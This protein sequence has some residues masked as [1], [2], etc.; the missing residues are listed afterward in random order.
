MKIAS[1]IILSL[2]TLCV[3]S[4]TIIGEKE[5]CTSIINCAFKNITKTIADKQREISIVNFGSD[6]KIIN[7][8]VQK[9][10]N[11]SY[12]IKDMKKLVGNGRHEINESAIMVFDNLKSLSEFNFKAKFINAGPKSFQFFVYVPGTTIK[13]ISAISTERKINTYNRKFVNAYIFRYRDVSEIAHFQYFLVDEGKLLKLYTFIWYS[14][15]TC[16]RQQIVEVKFCDREVQ[17]FSWLHFECS[18]I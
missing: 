11:L 16:G 18:W 8:I 10:L 1:F 2:S 7:S 13:E 3:D 6:M 15:S 12:K 9:D 5:N 17:N 4:S 14:S